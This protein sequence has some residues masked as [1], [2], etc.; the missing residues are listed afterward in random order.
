MKK[1]RKI[2]VAIVL[3]AGILV[4]VF[5][6]RF[7]AMDKAINEQAAKVEAV[8]LGR[9]DNGVY[10]GG[11]SNYVMSV[12]VRVAIADSA[13]VS[14]DIVDHT[15]YKGHEGLETVDRIVQAQSPKVDAVSGATASSK[16]IMIAVHRA[17]T[18]EPVDRIAPPVQAV[19]P[20]DSF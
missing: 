1:L 8:D 16:C 6:L 15:F 9:L 11:F 19:V 10:A 12:N 2:L 13:I 3:I 20:K 18:S 5:F 7:H 4:L 14:V 17:L